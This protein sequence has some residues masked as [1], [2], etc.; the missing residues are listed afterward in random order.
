MAAR[1][2]R[3]IREE[4]QDIM[5]GYLE[6]I[7]I[8]IPADMAD[9]QLREFF[10][11]R[12][13]LEN[14]LYKAIGYRS[15]DVESTVEQLLNRNSIKT[16][17]R[18]KKYTNKQI[19]TY[20]KEYLRDALERAYGVVENTWSDSYESAVAFKEYIRI[21]SHTKATPAPAV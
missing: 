2:Q 18:N 13:T 16:H 6:N 7:E 15:F 4:F 17:G 9:D 12:L 3:D 14:R 8:P 5:C 21:R 11:I 19:R 10:T 1:L 20:I